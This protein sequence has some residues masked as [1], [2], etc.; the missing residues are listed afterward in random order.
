[1]GSIRP[2]ILKGDDQPRYVL[3]GRPVAVGSIRPRIL[4]GGSASEKPRAAMRCCS[5]LDPTEDTESLTAA[6]EGGLELLLQWA[7]SDRGY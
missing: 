3:M 2:R 1:V 4:K 7:R 5:G 6:A